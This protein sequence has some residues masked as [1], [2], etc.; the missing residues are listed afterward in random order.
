MRFNLKYKFL[1][2][3][4]KLIDAPLRILKFKHSKWRLRKRFLKFFRRLRFFIY[5]KKK[6][7]RGRR[8]TIQ[9]NLK[10]FRNKPHTSYL[11]KIEK[12][13]NFKSNFNLILTKNNFT[14]ISL[15]PRST[16]NVRN[17][18][19]HKTAKRWK[20]YKFIYKN[21]LRQQKSY[22]ELLDNRFLFKDLKKNLF[23]SFDVANYEAFYCS[24]MQ[25]EFRL[26]ILLYRLRYFRSTGQAILYA[27][28]SEIKVN[29]NYVQGNFLLTAGDI[30][31]FD[32]Q[33]NFFTNLKLIKKNISIKRFIEID[34]YSN[35]VIFLLSIYDIKST[36]FLNTI[37]RPF[38]LNKFRHSFK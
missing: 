15:T 12:R 29:S 24:L 3:K 8:S 11:L 36:D 17:I 19:T 37:Q 4:K 10:L 23:C 14:A 31:S 26:D 1:S 5:P 25:F 30:I 18:N 21:S 7:S 28:K 34:L 9:A 20:K 16:S 13:K 22:R 33:I 2:L 32:M 6:S 35:T 27:N 38:N